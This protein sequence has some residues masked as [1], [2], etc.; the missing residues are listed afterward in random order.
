VNRIKYILE[1]IKRAQK[2]GTLSEKGVRF[3]R[4]QTLRY[5]V[6][7]LR[8]LFKFNNDLQLNFTNGFIDHRGDKNFLKIS[9]DQ[10]KRIVKAY[11][12]AKFD[13]INASPEFQI[14]GLWDEWISINF[15]KLI[16][17][18]ETENIEL[19]ENLFNN[20]IREQCTIGLGGY[21]EWVRYNSLFGRCYIK[22]VWIDYFNK[23]KDIQGNGDIE[24]PKVGN[25]CGVVYKGKIIPIESLRHAY[26]AEEIKNIL[27]IQEK[28]LVVEIGGGY[29]GL[30][31]QL[32]SKL[33]KINANYILFDIPEV[34]A[35][36]SAFL[37]TALPG[38]EI[39]LYGEIPLV[40][41]KNNFEIGIFPHFSIESLEDDSVDLFYNSCSFSEMNGASAVK[42]LSVIDRCC[43]KYF[44]HDNHETT[45]IFRQ[46]DGSS[47]E[48]IIG[49]KL[50]P[51][52]DYFKRI[53]KKIRTHGLPEDGSFKHFEYLYERIKGNVK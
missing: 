7:P 29:G 15:K 5:V 53:Y 43:R 9:H 13:Q 10:I 40:G 6:I 11:K 2:S 27:N 34:V 38:K 20:I 39:M 37:L 42:Y 35:I 3:F 26:R 18:L 30:G 33:K 46:Y 50:M 1:K 4:N 52:P 14:K 21:D 28:Q 19:L 17:A 51:N 22:E 24:F 41:I 25:P 48:N 36:S 12:L 32:I 44:M 31:Y 23:L 47:S 45:F 49:S 16:F 8:S